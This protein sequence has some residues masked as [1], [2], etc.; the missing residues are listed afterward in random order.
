M[1]QDMSDVSGGGTCR[2][3]QQIESEDKRRDDGS[4]VEMISDLDPS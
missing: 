2:V 4:T 3:L 1:K